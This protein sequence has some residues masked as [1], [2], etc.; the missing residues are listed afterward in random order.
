MWHAVYMMT[1]LAQERPACCP[2]PALNLDLPC[3]GLLIFKHINTLRHQDMFKFLLIY[4]FTSEMVI[5]ERIL[6][7][8]QRT[9]VKDQAVLKNSNILLKFQS[10]LHLLLFYNETMLQD[11]FVCCVN[12]QYSIYS[13]SVYQD[14]S[15]LPISLKP[16]LLVLYKLSLLSHPPIFYFPSHV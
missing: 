6:L 13:D 9:E 3:L 14:V 1:I 4:L 7:S 2:A 15:L 11:L 12:Y 8:G 5:G 10:W 16:L